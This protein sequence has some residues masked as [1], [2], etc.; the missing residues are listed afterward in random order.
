MTEQLSHALSQSCS[1]PL[2][3]IEARM[4]ELT[5]QQQALL[6]AVASERHRLE[7]LEGADE[8][9]ALMA[10]LPEHTEKL[11]HLKAIVDR[12]PRRLNEIGERADS[13]KRRRER[14]QMEKAAERERQLARERS[15]RAQPT[16]DAVVVSKSGDDLLNF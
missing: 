11:A 10:R 16:A 8:A 14:Q 6:S 4:Q 7:S 2:N 13:V 9:F 3:E 15:L 1:E 5:K 12:L